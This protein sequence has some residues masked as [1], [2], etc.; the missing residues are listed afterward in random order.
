MER[1]FKKQ[2]KVWKRV[3]WLQKSYKLIGT[4]YKFLGLHIFELFAKTW[5]NWELVF[6][7]NTMLR[8]NIS[9]PPFFCPKSFSPTKYVL[10]R[11]LENIQ[12]GRT[13]TH[14]PSE[15]NPAANGHP[16]Q[17]AH[18]DLY[19]NN[20]WECGSQEIFGIAKKLFHGRMARGGHGL[21]KVSV[22]PAMPYPSM[23]CGQATPEM[24]L[25]LFQGGPP[26]G[27]AACRRILPL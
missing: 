5:N 22:G 23:P 10:D 27:L 14:S 11:S 25:R 8:K 3:K 16:L 7:V 12:G 18:V 17:Y 20:V 13:P 4:I 6:F 21:P 19:W 1:G 26:I 2:K 24:S 15:E 9:L